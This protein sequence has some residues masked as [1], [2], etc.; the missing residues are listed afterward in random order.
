[1]WVVTWR[2]MGVAG[3]V[4]LGGDVAVW[5]EMGSVEGGIIGW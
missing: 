2:G 4:L 5:L 3:G 1:M